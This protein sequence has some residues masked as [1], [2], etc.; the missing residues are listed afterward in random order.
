MGQSSA[1]KAPD[2]SSPLPRYFYGKVCGG[3]TRQVN[4]LPS[5]YD[6]LVVALSQIAMDGHL[7]ESDDLVNAAAESLP[8]ANATRQLE[9]SPMDCQA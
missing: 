4:A 9:I 8:R 3:G 1:T 7:V 5:A 6:V 2:L